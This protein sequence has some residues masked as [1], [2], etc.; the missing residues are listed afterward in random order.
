MQSCNKCSSPFAARLSKHPAG[1]YNRCQI[2][3]A[4]FRIPFKTG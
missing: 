1:N 4:Q 2:F 3:Q